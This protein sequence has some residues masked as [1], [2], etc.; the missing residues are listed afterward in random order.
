MRYCVN[1]GPRGLVMSMTNRKDGLA[2]EGYARLGG[3]QAA[4]IRVLMFGRTAYLEWAQ[5]FRR[6]RGVATALLAWMFTK[7]PG[8][9]RKLMLVPVSRAG[10]RF[11][12]RLVAQQSRLGLP[13]VVWSHPL[14]A[15]YAWRDGQA[16]SRMALARAIGTPPGRFVRR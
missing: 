9:P 12:A 8:R 4:Y 3:E 11:T 6:H 5:S 16:P 14:D 1:L 2:F 7:I 10:A 15:H 13:E